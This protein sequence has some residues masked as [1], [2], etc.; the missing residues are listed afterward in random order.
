MW[1]SRCPHSQWKET[2]GSM[3]A[4]TCVRNRKKR[5][6]CE[7]DRPPFETE[8]NRGRR[9][10]DHPRSKQKETGG[11]V[12]TTA[13]VQDGKKRG[14]RVEFTC[15]GKCILVAFR[16]GEFQGTF[17]YQFRNARIPP[18]WETTG[19]AVLA[20]PSANFHSAGI[21]RIQQESVGH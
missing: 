3:N 15:S 17:R 18:E 13:P 4:T 16:S 12:N 11:D 7:Y 1:D 6:R 2:G 9:E 14:Q 20:E 8:R 5:G 21:T 19:M 10:Y